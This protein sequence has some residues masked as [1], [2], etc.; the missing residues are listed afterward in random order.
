MSGDDVK[1]TLVQRIGFTPSDAVGWLYA[2]RGLYKVK[3]YHLCIEAVSHCLRHEKTLK[4]AQHLLGF[5]LLHTGQTSAAAAAFLKSV[6][7]PCFAAVSPR[8]FAAAAAG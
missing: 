7:S 1:G 3:D 6:R 8:C 4:E 2:A 5:S